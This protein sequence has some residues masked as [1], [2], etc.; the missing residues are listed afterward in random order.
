MSLEGGGGL[1]RRHR[2]RRDRDQVG[3]DF[4]EWSVGNQLRISRVSVSIG[5]KRAGQAGAGV[6]V[7]TLMAT[8]GTHGAGLRPAVRLSCVYRDAR[9]R[10]LRRSTAPTAVRPSRDEVAP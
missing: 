3:D 9:I 7:V 1:G 10:G 4:I 8:S 2:A 5:G 6:L